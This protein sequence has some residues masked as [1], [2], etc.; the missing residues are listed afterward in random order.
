MFAF[1]RDHH[2]SPLKDVDASV[3]ASYNVTNR[4][5]GDLATNWHRNTLE[6]SKNFIASNAFV[7]SK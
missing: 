7:P 5:D 1:L 4:A 6:W 3:R 2:F